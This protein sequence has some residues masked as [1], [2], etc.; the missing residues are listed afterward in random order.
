[1]CALRQRQRAVRLSERPHR[2][3]IAALEL[4]QPGLA[5]AL[6]APARPNAS[7]SASAAPRVGFSNALFSLPMAP[8]H[9]PRRVCVGH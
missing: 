6:A 7:A 3:A 2:H 1:M 8:E 5:A 4:Q 9:G